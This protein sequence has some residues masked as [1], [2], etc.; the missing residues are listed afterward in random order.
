MPLLMGPGRSHHDARERQDL[1]HVCVSSV[2]MADRIERRARSLQLA[3]AVLALGGLA[4]L[5]AGATAIT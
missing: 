3:T 4:T 5:L 2:P 1:R